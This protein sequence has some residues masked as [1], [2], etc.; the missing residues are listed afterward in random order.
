MCFNGAWDALPPLSHITLGGGSHRCRVAD[1]VPGTTRPRQPVELTQ[2][3]PTFGSQTE[4]GPS[5]LRS[6][7]GK[8]MGSKCLLLKALRGSQSFMAL[9][10][11]RSA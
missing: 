5:R 10:C 2:A 1:K 3:F 9:R 6:A 4:A 7:H 11:E 8:S